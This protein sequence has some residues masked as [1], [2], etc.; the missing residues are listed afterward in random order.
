MCY[1]NGLL[2][3]KRYVPPSEGKSCVYIHRKYNKI[4]GTYAVYSCVWHLWVV[5][6][7]DGG[8]ALDIFKS[9]VCTYHIRHGPSLCPLHTIFAFWASVARVAGGVCCPRSEAPCILYVL[10]SVSPFYSYIIRTFVILLGENWTAST[11]IKHEIESGRTWRVLDDGD[12][13]VT[14][15]KV[16]IITKWNEMT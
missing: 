16:T 10:Y 15:V 14:T 3:T 12:T 8:G 1:I 2:L 9:P 13:A 11:N 7:D 5:F 6:L 4:A